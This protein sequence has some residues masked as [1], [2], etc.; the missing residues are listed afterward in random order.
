M[1]VLYLIEYIDKKFLSFKNE[2]KRKENDVSYCYNMKHHFLNIFTDLRART[3]VENYC[4]N[5]KVFNYLHNDVLEIPANFATS[6]LE[7]LS[8]I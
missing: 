8:S 5:P 4:D 6:L 2:T 1:P 3:L 7:C